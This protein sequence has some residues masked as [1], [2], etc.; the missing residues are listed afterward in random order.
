MLTLC[1]RQGGNETY[2]RNLILALAQIDQE[3]QYFLLWRGRSR[4]VLVWRF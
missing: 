4:P 1:A 3:N 2:I